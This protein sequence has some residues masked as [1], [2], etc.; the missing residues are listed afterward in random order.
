MK[1]LSANLS[2]KLQNFAMK[3]LKTNRINFC[4]W[5]GVGCDGIYNRYISHRK[6]VILEGHTIV[7]LQCSFYDKC[8]VRYTF[9]YLPQGS[10]KVRTVRYI[11]ELLLSS[12]WTYTGVPSAVGGLSPTWG[13]GWGIHCVHRSGRHSLL[14]PPS[15]PWSSLWSQEA[16]LSSKAKT[17][18]EFGFISIIPKDKTLIWFHLNYTQMQN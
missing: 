5:I 17:K 9:K 12:G 16:T 15:P 2:L 10:V 6:A 13:W 7:V 1:T 4:K 18:L 11:P 3:T 14:L 8:A